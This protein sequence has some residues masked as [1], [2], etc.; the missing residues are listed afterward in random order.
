LGGGAEAVSGPLRRL[1]AELHLLTALADLGGVWPLERVT[2]A[3]SA[4][5]DAAVASALRSLAHDLRAR[6]VL[7]SLPDD[8]RGPL[9]GLFLLAMGKHGAGELNYSSDIDVS[10][11]WEPEVVQA[12]LSGSVEPQ[13]IM[14]RLAQGLATL[15]SERTGEGY[16]FRT[17]LRLRPDPS[18]TPPAVAAPMAL[19]YYES[20]GQNWE[21]AAFI[22][23][24]P[25]AGDLAEARAFLD[26]LK[27]FVWR[28]SLD[29]PAILDI[30]SIKRQIHAWKTG[31]GLSAGGA[32]LKLG[33]GGIRE[34]E[35]Y[36]QTQQLILG[37]RDPSLRAPRTVEALAALAA[38]AR[39]PP[40]VA[41]ALTAAYRRLRDLEH[42]V[43]MLD[44]E[45]SHVLPLDPDRRR[46]VAAL[47]GAGDLVAF[48]AG[49]EALL[50]AV[51]A[52][53]GELFSEEED[54]SSQW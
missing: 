19:A 48:D 35:F 4:F 17:D 21:R 30:Q 43:Q 38:A 15:L 41:E 5:A 46:A 45:Q 51:N 25:L 36:A 31:Q 3:L 7:T 16:V 2:G 20:V 18:S 9:P 1:K 52:R 49:V 40:E 10:V 42:R 44:D 6:G 28:R 11:F 33:R 26:A 8:P 34:I 32:N 37:G 14:D 53:Y 12:V 22:K 47:A 13:R 54:L 29:Y 50:R 23:A 39:T 27:P 24:R